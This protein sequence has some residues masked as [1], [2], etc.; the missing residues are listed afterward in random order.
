MRI[1]G[2]LNEIHSRPIP[3]CVETCLGMIVA[4]RQGLSVVVPFDVRPSKLLVGP[5]HLRHPKSPPL[6]LPL[7]FDS[8]FPVLNKS[9]QVANTKIEI[10]EI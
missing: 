4:V 3:A 2:A 6:E 1:S 8:P 10:R 7:L 9:D 5:V